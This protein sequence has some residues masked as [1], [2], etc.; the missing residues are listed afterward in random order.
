MAQDE[1][2]VTQLYGGTETE[3]DISLAQV[4]EA[5]DNTPQIT[6]AESGVTAGLNIKDVRIEQFVGP[7]ERY[8][9]TNMTLITMQVDEPLGTSLLETMRNAALELRVRNLDKCPYFLELTFIGYQGDDSDGNVGDTVTN[10]LANDKFDNGGRWLYEVAVTNIDTELETAGSR[11]TLSMRPHNESAFDN[12]L[13]VVPSFGQAKGETV[14]QFLESFKAQLNELW[15]FRYGRPVY[16]F[17][18]KLHGINNLEGDDPSQ[19]RIAPLTPDEES[20][21][22]FSW[23]GGSALPIMHLMGGAR[24]QDVIEHLFASTDKGAAIIKAVKKTM[25]VDE[26]KDKSTM[27]LFRK[28]ILLRIEPDVDLGIYDPIINNYQK[29]ITFH[30]WGYY[31][32]NVILSRAQEINASDNSVQAHMV[33]ELLDKGFFRKRYDYLFTGLNTEV[34]RLDIKYNMAWNVALPTLA[35]FGTDIEQSVTNAKVGDQVLADRLAAQR[36]TEAQ[37]E[38][39]KYQNNV[40]EINN[41]LASP[42]LTE[43][44]RRRLQREYEAARR[45]ELDARKKV[46]ALQAEQLEI[47]ARVAQTDQDIRASRSHKGKW[48]GYAEDL[49]TPSVQDSGAIP[50]MIS[51]RE[52]NIGEGK[53]QTGTGFEK[54]VNGERGIYGAILEQVY[55][56]LSAA[57]LNIEMDIRGDP[58]WLSYSNIERRMH[59]RGSNSP[60]LNSEVNSPNYIEGDNVVQ[61]HFKYPFNIDS[62]TGDINI[63][64]G[65]KFNGLYRITKV[66]HQF[67]GGE[68]KQTLTGIRYTLV[69]IARALEWDGIEGGAVSKPGSTGRTELVSPPPSAAAG[70]RTTPGPAAGPRGI[71]NNNPGNIKTSSIRWQGQ[72]GSDGT[73]VTF[74]TPESGIRALSKNLLAKQD[75]HGLG[76]VRDII[77]DQ[78]WGWAPA[79]DGNDPVAYSKF[80]AERMGVSPTQQINLHDPATL[81]KFTA[82]IIQVENGKQPYSQSII[83]S[84]VS[85]A[86]AGD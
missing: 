67:A 69:D 54:P 24:I 13:N 12:E 64:A 28:S 77:S 26:A 83:N 68:F 84:G 23:V 70:A 34:L 56:P 65:D 33:R 31:T 82:A 32:Q 19:F 49:E 79:S 14:G 11:Y 47:A 42:D 36:Y 9:N 17:D 41:S 3:K 78:T 10:L 6:I 52:M 85:R 37:E 4:F 38:F 15:R 48:R 16:T 20:I 51:Y 2:F 39:K 53:Q 71:R 72:T 25:D 29:H 43:E 22:S 21:R 81:A 46:D 74:D 40:V 80:V 7:T 73:F 57:L 1:D 30:I 62:E 58:Y 75:L 61:L 63:R 8:R 35:Q 59:M 27:D 60:V 44:D 55:G 5:I 45:A 18:F 76:T 86:L 50:L 66:I